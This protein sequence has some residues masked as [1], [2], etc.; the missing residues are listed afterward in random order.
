MWSNINPPPKPPQGG[1]P[2]GSPQMGMG[3]G[4]KGMNGM[5]SPSSYTQY[6]QQQQQQPQQ[7]K[8]AFEGLL[9]F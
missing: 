5:P 9:K 7:G 1:L 3:M 8:D 2:G 6:Q 4:N